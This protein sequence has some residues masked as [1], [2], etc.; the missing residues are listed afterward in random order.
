MDA[1]KLQ[2][3]SNEY[4]YLVSTGKLNYDKTFRDSSET[5]RATNGDLRENGENT[6]C[7]LL[8]LL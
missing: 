8:T 7:D 3:T 6:P 5:S 1:L 2:G 4:A